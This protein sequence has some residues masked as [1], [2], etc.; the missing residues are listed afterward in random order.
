MKEARAVIEAYAQAVRDDV[1]TA[2]ATIV[3]VEGSAYRRPGARML[4]TADGQITGNLSGGCLE[5]D[6]FERARAV[7][8]TGGS[9]VV[10][11][12]TGTSA[13]IVWGLGLGC[14]GVVHTLIEP[15]ASDAMP[16]HL[17]LLADCITGQES[18]VIATV[19]G[20]HPA[21]QLAMREDEARI[22]IGSRLL[23]TSEDARVEL[24]HEELVRNVLRDA[25]ECLKDNASSVEVYELATCTAEVFI[26]VIEPPVPLVI[27]GANADAVP[28]LEFANKFGWHVT[29]VDTQARAASRERFAVAD[30]VLLCRPEDVAACVPLTRRTM[31]VVMTH[32]YQHDLELFKM[33]VSSPARYIG[34]LGPKRRTEQI[35]NEARAE[36]IAPNEADMRRF[37]APVG[38]DLGA[39]T[40][41]EI[42]LSIVAEIR[43]V[44]ANHE[45][46][47]L[48]N[49]VAPIHN[50]RFTS[51]HERK[52]DD[53]KQHAEM[54]E[55]IG[56]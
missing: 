15:L 39:E 38:L 24:N 52:I 3:R 42:A 36:G 51:E 45:G 50:A 1:Q 11:Y 30:A 34:L 41:E 27:F 5:R 7:M 37:H 9:I 17:K 18:C 29:V 31:A 32:N 35:I 22:K 47:F 26:E 46:G 8:K 44:L 23:L 56:A 28:V 4:M 19:F 43:A 12:D 49:R 16:Q 33:L 55:A 53:I 14:N 40:P 6:V 13:D 25:R 2:L 54:L 21:T 10:R 20:V 48:K